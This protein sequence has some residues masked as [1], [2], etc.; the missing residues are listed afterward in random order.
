MHRLD[1]VLKE[2][3]AASAT[4]DT[5][6]QI[7]AREEKL[8][9]LY[10]QIACEFAD[11]HDRTGRMEA[12]GVI[13]KGLEWR[14]AREFFY[15]RIRHRLQQ[16]EAVRGIMEAD[17]SMS[18]PA[19]KELVATW[20]PEGDD[21]EA[22]VKAFQALP[23]EERLQEIKIASLKKQLKEVLAQLPEDQRELK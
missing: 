23:L 8:A 22:A 6:A 4:D 20:V 2:L 3:D 17:S 9:P 21:D 12:K 19:A 13:R 16:Q 5:K 11:L 15:W 1:P 14:R 7:K 18:L 10:T